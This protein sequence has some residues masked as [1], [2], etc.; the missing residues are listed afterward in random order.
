MKNNLKKIRQDRSYTQ[1]Q[2]AKLAGI[3]RPYLSELESGN[4]NPS[5]SLSLKL[6]KI[7]SCT[8]EDIFLSEMSY[9]VYKPKEDNR[10]SIK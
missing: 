8:V 5:T 1:V 10:E 7:L 3:S 4:S 2:L 6:A 9:K